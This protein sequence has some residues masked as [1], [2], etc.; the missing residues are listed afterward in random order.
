MWLYYQHN[1]GCY[2]FHEIRFILFLRYHGIKNRKRVL[3]YTFPCPAHS[4]WKKWVEEHWMM[5]LGKQCEGARFRSGH[6]IMRVWCFVG[7]YKLYTLLLF[8]LFHMNRNV[9]W[10]S[11]LYLGMS[12]VYASAINTFLVALECESILCVYVLYCGFMKL[13]WG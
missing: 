2:R 11:S 4:G 12:S 5:G 7:I 8:L 10:I 1:L 6:H 13:L 9:L 3:V